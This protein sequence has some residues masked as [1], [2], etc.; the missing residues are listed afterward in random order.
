MERVRGCGKES[1]VVFVGGILTGGCE[2]GPRVDLPSGKFPS[3]LPTV[4]FIRTS[5]HHE[6]DFP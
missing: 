1:G 5:M 3:S 2:E 6:Y 4:D